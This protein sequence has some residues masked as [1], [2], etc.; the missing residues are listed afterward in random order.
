M[1][2][3][4]LA[5]AIAATFAVAAVV[6]STSLSAQAN[7]PVTGAAFTTVN[8]TVDGPDH[9][10]NGNPGINCNIYD[11][12]QYV[13]LNGGPDTAYVGDG[14]YF[15]AVLEPGGQPGPND[16]GAKNLSD[17]VDS[18][19]DRT[20]SVAGGTV[21]YNGPHDFAENKI[22]L[23]EYADTG[24]PGG[25]YI[26]A[27]CSLADGYPVNPAHCKYD[28]FKV[29]G[30]AE[31][32]LPPSV[33][34]DADGSYTQTYTWHI[35]KSVDKTTVKQVGGSAT[36]TYT[37]TATHDG[38]AVS[39]VTVSGTISVLNP[40]V[41][42]SNDTV[43]IT[44]VDVI[45]Q[46][47][48]GTDCTVT[49]GSGVT[50]TAFQTDFAY[51]CDLS[52]VPQGELDNTATVTWSA[53][54]LDNGT[55][56]A[57]GTADFTFPGIAFTAHPVGDCATVNDT[58][59]GNL[60]TVCVGDDNPKA[61]TY[62]RIVPVPSAGCQTYGNTATFTANNGPTGTASQTVTVCGPADTGAL[63]IGFW[64][65]KNGQAIVKGGA[66]TA[67]V[68]NSAIWLRVYAPFQDLSSTAS[69][70]AVATYVT[71]VIKAAN[72]SGSSMNAMLKAQMLATALDV[73]FSDPAL[74]GNKIG[75]PAPIGGVAIDLTHVCANPTGCSSYIDASSAF[76]AAAS[77]T[78]SQ[79]LTYEASQSNAGGSLWYGNVKSTQEKAKDVND[80]INNEV[81]FAA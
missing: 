59:A 1:A 74:G 55:S 56:L 7:Q 52:A 22:R 63:T 13:W 35:A 73:Y 66:S 27:I 67:G 6:G 60:G 24:N 29:K 25:V 32:G 39:A 77:L 33:V 37:V 81:A 20:F 31:V 65:N 43:P 53:Q 3:R 61:F 79:I 78:V 12:K 72:A 49:G 71:N 68:C 46:L 48:D 41:N 8:E 40:N 16:G 28:A 30:E 5:L 15:F 19:T 26:M 11:G 62:K 17:N 80:A 42:A 9:C 18:Y 21:T 44:G 57:A 69:C 76:G 10:K 34:K 50:L 14:S 38:G 47:S 75:A 51:T 4:S 70:A 23:A 64:Q 45:D 36:F 54:N 2:K 58:Y